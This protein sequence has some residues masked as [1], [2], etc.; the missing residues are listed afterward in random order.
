MDTNVDQVQYFLSRIQQLE[1]KVPDEILEFP[2]LLRKQKRAIPGYTD[3]RLWIIQSGRFCLQN[4][5]S[6]SSLFES[7]PAVSNDAD[8][9]KP[10]TISGFCFG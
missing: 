8:A 4:Y 9:Q 10:E 3:V 1:S 6:D 7:P 5:S 2:L